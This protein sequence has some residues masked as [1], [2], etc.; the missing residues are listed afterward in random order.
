[1]TGSEIQ[2]EDLVWLPIHRLDVRQLFSGWM[3]SRRFTER[4][5]VGDPAHV[6]AI[7]VHQVQLLDPVT[8]RPGECDASCRH[9]RLLEDP[10]HDLVRDQ[11][12]RHTKILGCRVREEES[13]LLPQLGVDDVM[14]IQDQNVAFPKPLHLPGDQPGGPELIPESV[15]DSLPHQGSGERIQHLEAVRIAEVPSDDGLR[16]N[17]HP[18]SAEP[19]A[20][21]FDGQHRLVAGLVDEA[22]ADPREGIPGLLPGHDVHRPGPEIQNQARQECQPL[23]FRHSDLPSHE[24]FRFPSALLRLRRLYHS[25][26]CLESEDTIPSSPMG[27]NVKR[28]GSRSHPSSS[29]RGPNRPFPAHSTAPMAAKSKFTFPER[30]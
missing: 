1:M 23:R 7:R 10:L 24:R 6:L 22:Q 9:P 28:M 4:P 21:G 30:S 5:V 29:G 17:L 27:L 25:R 3:P 19:A 18:T 16:L 14:E 26:G 13:G 20:E 11:V 8:Q 2:F 15:V 12:H